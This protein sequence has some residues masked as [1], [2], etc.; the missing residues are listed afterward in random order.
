MFITR[1]TVCAVE[2]GTSKICVLI[3][4]ITPDG[5]L[6]ISGL[7]EVPS[8]GAVVKGEISDMKRA[9]TALRK[10]FDIAED[11]ARC[12]LS[13]CRMI[14]VVATGGGIE[15]QLETAGVT[16]NTPNGIV[17]ENEKAEVN[18]AARNLARTQGRE[19]INVCTSGYTLDHRQVVEPCGQSGKYLQADVHIVSANCRRLD[20]FIQAMREAG[21]EDARIEPVFTPLADLHG[22]VPPDEQQQDFILLDIGAGITEYLLCIRGGIQ[23]SGVLRVGMEHAANDLA[24]GLGLPIDKCRELFTGQSLAAAAAS[25]DEFINVT[26]R[27]HR[28]RKIPVSSCENIINERLR[29]LLDIVRRKIPVHYNLAALAAGGLITGGG[30]LYEPVKDIVSQVFDISCRVIKPV[31]PDLVTLENPRY[32]TIW[33]ALKI[34]RE[35]VGELPRP[36]MLERFLNRLSGEKRS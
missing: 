11:E 2:F 33:G 34:A 20:S 36:G 31:K 21:L 8:G 13:D 27:N 18:N 3:G 29:E 6:E 28:I 7:G 14:T 12:T 23:E 19:I 10:A 5:R 17:T 22:A 4:D 30:A 32:S 24:I 26:V 15:S 16:V 9:V 35:F 1:N 25:R